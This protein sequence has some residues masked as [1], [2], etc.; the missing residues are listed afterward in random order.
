[1]LLAKACYKILLKAKA[2]GR[3]LQQDLVAGRGQQ[4]IHRGRGRGCYYPIVVGLEIFGRKY[5][6]LAKNYLLRI[7]QPNFSNFGTLRIKNGD[8][9][10]ERRA[11][12][13]PLLGRPQENNCRGKN[14]EGRRGNKRFSA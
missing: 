13:E 5:A 6:F 12:S 8:H 10:K 4:H 11:Q 14:E 7:F 9:G 2:V 3:G 1:M